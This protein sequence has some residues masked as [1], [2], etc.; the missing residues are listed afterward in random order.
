MTETTD[1]LDQLIKDHLAQGKRP[2]ELLAKDGLLGQLT[3]ALVERC[4]EA[5]MDDHLGYE[6]SERAGKSGEN[7]RNGYSKKTVL[8]DQGELSLGVPR[9]RNGEFEPQA[10]PKRQNRLEGFDDKILAM[11]ARGMTVRDTPRQLKGIYG[12]DFSPTLIS[13]VTDAVMDEVNTWQTRPLDNVYPIVFF[14]PL[15]G[16]APENHRVI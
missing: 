6:K 15:G 3:K 13:N 7:R 2:K 12:A 10:V 1:I 5:E 8:S 9:D 16:K 4:L 14:A 11:Y